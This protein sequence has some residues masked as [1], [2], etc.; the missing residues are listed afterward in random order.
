MPYMPRADKKAEKI[1][2]KNLGKPENLATK[3][4]PRQKLINAKLD[5]QIIVD[6]R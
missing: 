4:T 2:W 1:A 3:E 5:Y 6:G